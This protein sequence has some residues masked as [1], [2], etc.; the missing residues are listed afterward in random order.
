MS[1]Q[2]SLFIC[3]IG[4]QLPVQQTISFTARWQS[5]GFTEAIPAGKQNPTPPKEGKASQS[6]A[7]VFEVSY[8]FLTEETREATGGRRVPI[9]GSLSGAAQPLSGPAPH[10]HTSCP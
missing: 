7:F 4:G 3:R 5:G 10:P 8:P 2:A 1:G 9:A 6:Q